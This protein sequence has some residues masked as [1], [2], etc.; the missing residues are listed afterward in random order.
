M[1]NKT[2]LVAEFVLENKGGIVFRLI[3]Q[4][5]VRWEGVRR[6]GG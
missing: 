5:F 4:M 1:L 2:S 6:H 3:L